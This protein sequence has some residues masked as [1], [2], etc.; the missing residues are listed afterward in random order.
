MKKD[1][2]IMMF[3]E[4]EELDFVKRLVIDAIREDGTHKNDE[5]EKYFKLAAKLIEESEEACSE[6]ETEN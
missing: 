5:L 3:F 4:K 6:E 1:K 2:R